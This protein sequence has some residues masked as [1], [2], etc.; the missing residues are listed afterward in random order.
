[1]NVAQATIKDILANQEFLDIMS[2]VG[3]I[4]GQEADPKQMRFANV[5]FLAD[6]DVDGGHI[7][8]LL[9]N[10]FFQFWPEL[11]SMGCIQIAKAPLFEV[12]TDKKT[13]YFESD[14]ELEK[15]KENTAEKIREIFR[16]KGL[17]EMS[18]EAWKW[19]LSKE[20][21]TEIT[22]ESPTKAKQMLNI[23]FGK[24]ASLRKELLMD[25]NKGESTSVTRGK[26]NEESAAHGDY[27]SGS[28]K[29]T[30]SVTKKKVAKK[31][32]A[33]KA[34]TTK[35]KVAKKVKETKPSKSAKNKKGVLA[36]MVNYVD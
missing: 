2:S 18:P 30:K 34:T 8:T 4:L 13:H 9:T 19:V 12:V 3:L 21:Y 27:K 36:D 10:F 26:T 7:N 17:G 15:F 31:A 25:V 32:T 23:C 16:N 33:K 6:S 28:D 35:K 20:K 22:I 5:V 11:Y 14:S 1:M 29:P 24:D